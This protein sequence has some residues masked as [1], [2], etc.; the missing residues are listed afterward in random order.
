MACLKFGPGVP[1]LKGP[2][3]KLS[4]RQIGVIELPMLI[5]FGRDQTMQMYG[6]VD[7][8]PPSALVGLG[9]GGFRCFYIFFCPDLFGR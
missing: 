4:G 8:F 6:D 9:R 2:T 3:E 7:G 1:L 5:H